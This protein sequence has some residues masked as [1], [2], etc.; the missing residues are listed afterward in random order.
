MARTRH[1]TSV[2]LI[3][4]CAAWLTPGVVAVQDAAISGTVTDTTGLILPGVTAE[5]RDA[6]GG[7]PPRT[8]VTDGSGM[9]T[10]ALPPGTYDVTFTLPGFQAAVR[11]AVQVGAGATANVDMELVVELEERV[12]VV[13]SRAEPRSVTESRVPID[14][15]PF[16]DV[17]SQGV[18][19][20]DYQLRTLVPSFNVATHPNQRC[21]DAGAAGQHPQSR[22]RPHPGAG[23]RQAAPPLVGHRVVRRR[24]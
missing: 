18:T 11:S 16:Q 17:V 19:T 13:G 24:D 3:G 20:L 10:I 5:A 8:A 15:I 4:L 12:V 7:G 22:P 14:A 6:A 23:Q 9:F 21:G 2:I 1:T